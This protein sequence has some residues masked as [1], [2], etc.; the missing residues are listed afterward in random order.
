MFLNILQYSQENTCVGVQ[1]RCFSVNI[2]KFLRTPIFKNICERLLCHT[3]SQNVKRINFYFILDET[4]Q[5]S[6]NFLIAIVI[7]LECSGSMG[8]SAME[9]TKN[10]PEKQP[11][12]F[13]NSAMRN[14]C[15]S[16]TLGRLPRYWHLKISHTWL[17]ISHTWLKSYLKNLNFFYYLHQKMWHF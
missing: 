16:I 4:L 1:R 13:W 8:K 11:T 9:L 6:L 12:I 2:T 15:H 3:I 5:M 14:C 7:D 10:D 17:K